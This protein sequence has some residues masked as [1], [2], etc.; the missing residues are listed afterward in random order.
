LEQ[1]E[2]MRLKFEQEQQRVIREDEEKRIELQ[3][4]RDRLWKEHEDKVISRLAELCKL[5]RYNFT[6][7]TN[8]NLPE[9]FE[10]IIEPDFMIEFLDQYIIFDAKLSKKPENMNTY[11]KNAVKETVQKAKKHPKIF[12]T[13]F[14]V[15]PNEGIGELKEHHYPLEGYVV[16][17][18]AADALPVVLWSIKQITTYE[19]AEQMDPQQRENIIQLIA[20]LDFHINVRNAADVIFAKMGTDLLRKTQSSDA[21]LAEEVAIRKQPMNAKAINIGNSIK[22]LV[23]NLDAQDAEIQDLVSPEV[24]IGKKEIDTAEEIIKA[25]LL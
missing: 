10:G 16:H 4:A 19:F 18:I 3:D 13:I 12:K 15:V 25:H 2:N 1:T 21:A 23:V 5:P 22:K 17:T 20:E 8:Q 11:I 14:L 6:V 7:F 9:G 24:S